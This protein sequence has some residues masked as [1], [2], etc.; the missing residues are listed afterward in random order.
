M[1]Q[2]MGGVGNMT[3]SYFHLAVGVILMYDRG[4]D[5]TL[6]DLMEWIKSIKRHSCWNWKNCVTF[7]LWGNDR[8]RVDQPV[9]SEDLSDFRLQCGVSDLQ[10]SSVNAHMGR[11]VCP[12]YQ[13]LVES[14]HSRL[15]MADIPHGTYTYGSE[16]VLLL[17]DRA[18]NGDG[19]IDGDTASRCW[20]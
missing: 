5:R 11:N 7:V 6:W 14:I 4:C 12:S 17:E 9:S 18:I 19:A 3:R 1:E 10:H 20:C 8:N 16:E 2:G 13:T 15:K